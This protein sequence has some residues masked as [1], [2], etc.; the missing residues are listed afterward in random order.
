ML[1]YRVLVVGPEERA[2][3]IAAGLESLEFILVDID[4]TVVPVCYLIVVIEHAFITISHRKNI[5][6]VPFLLK[7][8][9]DKSAVS[10]Q[11]KIKAVAKTAFM[12]M[13]FMRKY[14]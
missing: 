7:S 3:F 9:F 12:I 11:D 13:L 6:P 8:L 5:P 4:I 10:F 2:V 14:Q 1:Y